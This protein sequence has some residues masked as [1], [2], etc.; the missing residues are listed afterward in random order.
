MTENRT[1]QADKKNIP[2]I[3]DLK[4]LKKLGAG[5]FGIVFLVGEKQKF[6]ALKVIDKVKIQKK[7]LETYIAVDI[8][9]IN[10]FLE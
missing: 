1:T 4:V 9:F 8:I 6:Y 7:S 3:D 10:S 5:E 2:D